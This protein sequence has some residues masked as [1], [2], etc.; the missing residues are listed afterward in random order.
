MLIFNLKSAKLDP[1]DK[2]LI[3]KALSVCNEEP[4]NRINIF[5]RLKMVK[6]AKF[7]TMGFKKPMKKSDIDE[8]QNSNAIDYPPEED[9]QSDPFATNY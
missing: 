4:G 1:S 7:Y 6:V 2:I 8:Y 3:A 9:D 5:Q